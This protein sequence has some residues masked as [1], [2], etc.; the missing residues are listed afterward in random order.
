MFTSLK[1]V[2]KRTPVRAVWDYVLQLKYENYLK[3]NSSPKPVYPL[4]CLSCKLYFKEF[5]SVSPYWDEVFIKLGSAYRMNQFETMNVEAYA[6]P[7]CHIDDRDRLYALYLQKK[8][9]PARQYDL[10]EFA[11]TD[12]LAKVLK[13]FTNV[14]RRTADLFMDAVDDKVD[15]MDMHIYKNGSFDFFIC[16]HVLE[17]V[18]DDVKAMRELYRILKPG[19][20]GIAMVPIILGL[21]KTIEDPS[22]KDENLRWKYFG[23]GDHVRMYRR[24][25]YLDRLAGVGFTVHQYGKEYFGE[26]VFK[27]NG[28]TPSSV[29]YVVEK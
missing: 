24:Q 19:G 14:R 4:Y 22:I 1:K 13:T 11:P 6:C 5:R 8:L 25:D 29:L 3:K 16:S 20:F 27:Q 17:H 26:A 28:I 7:R 10:V 12:P 15:L 2:L 9:N 21:P 23:Q 18:D